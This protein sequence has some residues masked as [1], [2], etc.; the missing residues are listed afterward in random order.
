[1]SENPQ[2]VNKPELSKEERFKTNPDRWVCLD[3][4]VIAL[5][6]TEQGL[7]MLCNPHDRKEAIMAKGECDAV[8]TKM[9]LKMDIVVDEKRRG[10]I[11]TP[12]HGILDAARRGIFGKRG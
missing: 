11:V 1:M 10:N 9:I 4:L 5:L 8:L 12:K 6:R 7:A 3:D 2:E